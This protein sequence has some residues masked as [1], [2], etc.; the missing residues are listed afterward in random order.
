MTRAR[1]RVAVVF[2][3]RNGEHDESYESAASILTHLDGRRYDIVAVR[4]SADGCWTVGDPELPVRGR[5][6]DADR[7]R[8]ICVA[9]ERLRGVDIV[10]PALHGPDGEDGTI[11]SVLEMAGLSYV[12]N[13][14]LASAAGMDREYA[15]KLLA[16]AGLTVTEGVVLRAGRSRLTAAE[17]DRLGLPVRVRPARAGASFASVDSWDELPAA[18]V[19]ARRSDPKV[20]VEKAVRGRAIDIGVLEA[21]DGTVQVSPAMETDVPAVVDQ[22]TRARLDQIARQAF[23]ALDCTG[24]LRVSCFVDPGGVVVDQVNTFPGLSS[25]AP[26]ARMWQAAG[27]D[28]PE[29]LDTLIRTALRRTPDWPHGY[30]L[31]LLA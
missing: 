5:R 17:Q 12:G 10:F 25:G 2:G 1:T 21:P 27:L 7:L 14:T 16:A 31:G 28:Y 15:R 11:Q 13:G 4:I 18:I 20:L 9:L 3:G 23:T 8:S 26:Y 6:T 30:E 19:A 29:L 22:R 24:L